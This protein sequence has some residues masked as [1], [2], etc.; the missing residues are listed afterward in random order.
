MKKSFNIVFMGTPEYAVPTLQALHKSRHHISLVVT[1]PDRPKGRGRKV[2]SPPVKKTAA[3]FG[4]KVVQPHSVKTSEFINLLTDHNPDFIVVVAYGHILPESILSI[5]TIGPV[6]V[7]ASI[8]PKY[9][10]PAPIQWAIING[11]KQTGITTIMMDKG[12]DTGDIL[13]TATE[14]IHPEDT[15]A[16]LY[17]RLAVLG[18]KVLIET[19]NKFAEEDIHPTPQDHSQATLAPFLKKS[20]GRISWSKSAGDI[21]NFVRGMT[22]WPGAFTYHREKRLKIFKAETVTDATDAP[23]GTVVKGFTDE[24]RI[25]TGNGL[26]SILEL[27]GKSGKRLA[28]SDFLRGYNLSP[29]EMFE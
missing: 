19:L 1:Q 12:M 8:L 29:G 20:D 16:S 24:L 26:L 28:I 21:V 17:D 11:E 7:H 23:P 10:G 5:P 6:N 14:P 25:A 3:D 22:P 13:L 15:A 2:V 4:L 9:R 27:Q 18:G